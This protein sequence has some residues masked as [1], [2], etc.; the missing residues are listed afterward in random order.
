MVEPKTEEALEGEALKIN[1]T[2]VLYYNKSVV[3]LPHPNN[4]AR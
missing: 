3:E 1:T 4:E 2:K